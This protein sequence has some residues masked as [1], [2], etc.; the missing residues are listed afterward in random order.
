MKTKGGDIN[1][2]PFSFYLSQT[3]DGALYR[4]FK[5]QRKF[6]SPLQDTHLPLVWD[7]LLPL[8]YTPDRKDHRL[9]VYLPKDTGTC[10][11]T[12]IAYVSK[13]RQVGLTVRRSTTRLPFPT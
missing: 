5:V 6:V 7:L 13:R 2:T 11:V 3:L 9:L 10:G 4:A 8:A 1:Y 12:E